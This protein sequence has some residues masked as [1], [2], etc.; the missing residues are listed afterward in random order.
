MNRNQ[1]IAAIAVFAMLAVA[2]GAFVAEDVYA[3]NDDKTLIVETSPDFAPFEYTIGTQFVGIDMDLTRAIAKDMGYKV[4]F[5]INS[6]DSIIMSVQQGKCDLGASGFSYDE[7]RAKNV[8][9]SDFYA[10]IHQVVVI[11]VDSDIKT[12]EDVKDKKISVQTGTTGANYAE[13]IT[14]NVVFQKTYADVVNDLL[15]GKADCEVLDSTVGVAQVAAHPKELK[16]LDIL[17]DSPKENYGF[18][19]AK[20]NT[21]LCDKWNQS[22]KNIQDSGLYDD[23]MNYYEENGYSPDTPSFFKNNQ[24]KIIVETSPDFAPF[25]YT[26]GKEFSGID[27]D[28]VRAVAKEMGYKVEFRANS[29][30]S[31]IMSVQQG[32]CDIGASGFSYNEDRA[33]NVLFSEFYAEIHQV[34]VVPVDSNIVTFEDAKDKKISVQ[35]GTT[36]ADYAETISKNVVFQKAYADVVNDLLMGKSQAEVVDSTVAIAQVSAHPKELKVLDILKDSPVE[37]YGFVFANNN[38]SL[39][40]KFNAAFEEIKENGTYDKIMSYYKDHGYSP[41]TPPY[42]AEKNGTIVVE[43]SPDFPPFEYGFDG[44]YAG[45]DMDLARAIGELMNYNII[46]KDNDFDSIILSVQQGKCDMGAAG[47]TIDPERSKQVLFSDPYQEIH[48]V[49]VVKKGAQI[50]LDDLG[51]LTMVVQTGTSGAKFAESITKNIIYQKTYTTASLDVLSGKADCEV[52]DN[53]VAKAQVVRNPD[54]EILDVLDSEPEYYGMVFAKNDKGK[55]LC[56]IVNEALAKLDANGMIDRIATYYADNDFKEVPSYFDSEGYIPYE[57]PEPTGFWAKLADRFHTD[58]I[59]NDRYQYIFDG[60]K[61]TLII[62]ALALIMGMALGT[63]VAMI[64]SVHEQ[65]GKLRILN[66]IGVLYTTVI[67]GTPVMVQLMLIYYV[68]FATSSLNSVLIASV[69]FGLNSGAYVAEVVR[70]GINAVP[71]GQMEACRSLGLSNRQAM[72]SVILPQAVRNILPALGNE[73]ISLLK[74]TSVAGYIG[75]M[76]LTRGADIIRGQTYDA[77]LPML[78]AAAIYL[79]IVLVLAWLIK[80][81]EKRL[82]NAY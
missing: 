56:A 20:S 57:D 4:E 69:A 11:P 82:N 53:T 3:N 8:L 45:I 64:R 50:N 65:T 14:K 13:T 1:W 36:G 27:M 31:I 18:I 76:D 40:D 19:F 12:F 44:G 7:D 46:I 81:M 35:T 51:S 54:L 70:A 28:I 60:L 42:D 72:T 63:V 24:G 68:I 26:I 67:R 21:A 22:L 47:F 6:F 33:K 5:K 2:C 75:I 37:N 78:V 41:D 61:N 48:Q 74:E 17:D 49:L 39:C 32:K 59:K 80:K 79:S 34:L 58:F 52:V 9:F 66:G 15:T 55:E 73:G 71:K 30:D 25:D 16:M 29:F 77:L 10:D 62:A 43:T 38:T 23:I